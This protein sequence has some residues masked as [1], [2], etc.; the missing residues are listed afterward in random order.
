MD[1]ELARLLHTELNAA[2]AAVAQKHGLLF[3][4]ARL[5]YST[6]EVRTT[7]RL[8]DKLENVSNDVAVSVKDA[9]TLERLGLRI[10]DIG[11]QFQYNGKNWKFVG[12]KMRRKL[13]P[14]VAETGGKKFKLPLEAIQSLRR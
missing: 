3:E 10:T 9:L 5:T 13:Y 1:R 7:V 4:P 14:V 8:Y 6:S 11:V 12:L 2:M